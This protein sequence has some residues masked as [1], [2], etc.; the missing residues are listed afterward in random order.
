MLAVLD[1]RMTLTVTMRSGRVWGG[2][3]GLLP[4]GGTTGLLLGGATVLHTD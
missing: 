2:A 1:I 3:E 4:I